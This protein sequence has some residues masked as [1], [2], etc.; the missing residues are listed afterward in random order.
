MA[1]LHLAPGDIR[2]TDFE[3]VTTDRVQ[4]LGTML[5]ECVDE[6]KEAH[7]FLLEER[8]KILLYDSRHDAEYFGL[9]DDVHQAYGD[10]LQDSGRRFGHYIS[11]LIHN[12]LDRLSWHIDRA[13]DCRFLLNIGEPS[14][15]EIA[16]E[17]DPSLYEPGDTGYP[18]PQT[19]TTLSLPTGSLYVANNLVTDQAL[20]RPH[21][22]PQQEDR[23]VL[24]TCFYPEPGWEN[25]SQNGGLA[26][27][28]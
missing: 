1:E 7:D 2:L 25:R 14:S 15:V 5:L 12:K 17:W 19:S 18:A 22:T 27:H 20:L 13:G 24:R 10:L 3:V 23:L 26:I 4:E 9:L 11:W 8:F 6:L 28:L 16:D 21:Q